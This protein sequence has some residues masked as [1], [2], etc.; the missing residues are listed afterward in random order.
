MAPNVPTTSGEE[1]PFEAEK[2]DPAFPKGMPYS[3]QESSQR[4]MANDV[5][6]LL[7]LPCQGPLRQLVFLVP[8][9][10]EPPLEPSSTPYPAKYCTFRKK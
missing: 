8:C 10:H 7:C 3:P 5:S 6:H 9:I 2:I 4:G 1:V